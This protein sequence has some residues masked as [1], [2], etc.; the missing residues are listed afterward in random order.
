MPS[1][2][3]WKTTITDHPGS[4]A[5]DINDEPAWSTGHQHRIGFRNRQE[6]V[7]GLTH[8][9]DE[10]GEVPDLTNS[11]DSSELEEEAEVDEQAKE[12]FEKLKSR[13]EKGELLNF[14]DIVTNEK[15]LH[16]QYPQNR[17]VG[18]RYVLEASEDWVKNEEDWPA[19]LEKKKKEEAA[20]KEQET[21]TS[22]GVQIANGGK[23][24]PSAEDSGQEEND[25]KRKEGENSKHHDAYAGDDEDSSDSD[26]E[27]QHTEY[28]KLLERY[29]PQEIALLRALKHEKE[30]RVKLQQN[31]GKRK[32][33]QTHNRTTVAIDEQDQF[34]PDNWLPRS[35][36][37]IRL[38]GKHPV[39]RK[40]YANLVF[41]MGFWL[42]QL[43][44]KARV[45]TRRP[46]TFRFR[47]YC[48]DTLIVLGRVPL[49]THYVLP[50][51]RRG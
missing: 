25:W 36:D 44:K 8:Q 11:S 35:E 3:P 20:K 48:I 40:S 21:H 22:D 43:R 16:L 41:F 31:D 13:A 14:R 42:V 39:R 32:S 1:N 47:V 5:Q 37:L 2:I 7:P 29:S 33:P 45:A 18:W 26:R 51:E 10:E 27:G 15:D 17:S 34:S 38:T 4:S 23:E 9:G 19:N 49:L 12:D 28:Q 24:K 50:D 30:Y 6:H 46:L